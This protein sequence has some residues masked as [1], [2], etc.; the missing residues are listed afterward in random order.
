MEV[1]RF[2]LWYLI[3]D[4]N[5]I[6]NLT[7]ALFLSFWY[8]GTFTFKKPILPAG[9]LN[10][11]FKWIFYLIQPWPTDI[12]S[13]QTKSVKSLKSDTKMPSVHISQTWP[14]VVGQK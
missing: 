14:L 7:D 4:L 5:P 10:G 3:S 2:M 12:V 9:F 6:L 1:E 8:F 11:F 13:Y